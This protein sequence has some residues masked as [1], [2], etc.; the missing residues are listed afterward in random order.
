MVVV[1]KWQ[2][3]KIGA[4]ASTQKRSHRQDDTE[5]E[6][7]G[8]QGRRSGVDPTQCLRLTCRSCI[9]QAKIA[10][11]PTLKSKGMTSIRQLHEMY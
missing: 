7:A 2:F 5:I 8:E 10:T 3:G 9:G 11:N 1:L 6:A 4:P